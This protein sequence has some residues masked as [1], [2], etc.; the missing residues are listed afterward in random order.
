MA[1]KKVTDKLLKMKVWPL[2]FNSTIPAVISQLI[3][4]L[5]NVVDRM[6]VCC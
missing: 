5:Y 6:N 4:F 3:T 1:K 2:V